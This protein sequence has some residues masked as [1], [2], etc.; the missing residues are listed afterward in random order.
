MLKL[1]SRV[2]S[3]LMAGFVAGIAMNLLELTTYYVFRQPKVRSTDW[4]ALILAK[5]KPKSRSQYVL[6]HAGHLVFTTGLGGVFSAVV[7]KAADKKPVLK[8]WLWAIVS[9]AITQS[10]IVIAKLPLLSRLEW[11]ERFKHCL[12]VSVYG[13]VLG[14]SLPL[15]KNAISGGGIYSE[16]R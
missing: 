14:G 6:S 7:P 9:T 10:L 15:M 3:G 13:L 4:L 2:V 5:H 8:G 1:R 12:L 11:P 16:K